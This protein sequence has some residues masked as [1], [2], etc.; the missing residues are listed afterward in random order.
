MTLLRLLSAAPNLFEGGTRFAVGAA[1]LF[2]SE[3]DDVYRR[4]KIQVGDQGHLK[5]AALRD[6]VH[7]AEQR[8][9]GTLASL[10]SMGSL[11][12]FSTALL[13][14]VNGRQRNV[15]LRF[16][17]PDLIATERITATLDAVKQFTAAGPGSVI[18]RLEETRQLLQ[19]FRVRAESFGTAYST[20]F[21]G[22]L[23]NR[24][25]AI[26]DSEFENSPYSKPANLMVSSVEKKYPLQTE[27]AVV[28]LAFALV[29]DGPGY[30]SDVVAEA[31]VLGE[32]KC[33]DSGERF[34]GRLGIESL[35]FEVPCVVTA[36]EDRDL[37]EVVV[38]WINHD[39]SQGTITKEIEIAGQPQ[40]VD[41]ATL[42]YEDP[43]SAERS[44]TGKA[45]WGAMRSLTVSSVVLRSKA[46]ARRT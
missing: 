20:R 22:G 46:L 10:T 8:L 37:V 2:D 11:A 19:D 42:Q 1:R 9:D 35:V 14:E 26:V 21:A 43:Y 4:A 33:I 32:L 28:N 31:V 18:S 27:G 3:L 24:L 38:R 6:V 41:W 44:Q 36:S 7:D 40:Q 45:W 15:I 30:A 5:R 12:R 16:M 13:R 29:N 34:L 23:A 25:L 39:G 17:P